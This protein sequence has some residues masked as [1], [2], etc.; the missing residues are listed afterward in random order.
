MVMVA[1]SNTGDAAADT[2]GATV[3]QVLPALETGGV[4]RG[5]V[6]VATALHQ[7]GWRAVVASAG[8][9]MT[10][11]LDR[12]DAAHVD[13]PL[14]GKSPFRIHANIERLQQVIAEHNVDLVHARSR[15]PA[16]SAYYAARRAGVPFVTTYHS[17]YGHNWLK[18]WYNAIM[19][20]G[21]RV[22]AISNFIAGLIRRHYKVEADRLVTIPRGLDLSIFDPQAVT[23]ARMIALSRQWNLRADRPVIMLPGRLTRW[24]GQGVLIEALARLG[25]ED[26]ACVI[27]GSDQGR[28]AYRD[29]LEKLAA[30]RGVDHLL[31]FA[32]HCRDMA[33]A[34]MLADVVVSASTEPEGFGR[35]AVEAQAMGRPVVATDHG[36][37]RETVRHRETGWL[38]EPGNA[39]EMAEALGVALSLNEEERRWMS[40][41][42]RQNAVDNYSVELMCERTL[43]V[44][45]SLLG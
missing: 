35:V 23:Q 45:R 3:L 27:V 2:G 10:R 22:I 25:R 36:G 15:A 1:Q 24:K 6:Q 11:E 13:L 17:P 21:D 42:G 18:H 4:E 37:S 7:A 38:V 44:Y 28:E 29:E 32:D 26:V 33:A 12:I 30:A 20:R 39:E 34:Y 14:T 31:H 9:P 43:A 41:N 8:G 40:E 5:T 16:W 19:A